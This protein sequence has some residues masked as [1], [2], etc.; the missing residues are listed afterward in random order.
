MKVDQTALADGLRVFWGPALDH[1]PA[2]CSTFGET[3]WAAAMVRSHR[4]AMH[5]LFHLMIDCFLKH[6][7]AGGGIPVTS[8]NGALGVTPRSAGIAMPVAAA[9]VVPVSASGRAPRVNWAALD[10]RLCGEVRAAEAAIRAVEP[11]VRVTRAEIERRVAR[12]DWFGKR[13]RK[14]PRAVAVLQRLEEPVGEYR[15]R[16]ATHWIAALGPSCRPWEV[17]R[18]AGLRSEHL[19]MIRAAMATRAASAGR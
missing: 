6:L 18:A 5:P 16:R 7:Q 13:R 1:L 14:V 4:K 9:P 15:R 19:P 8:S 12:T 10:D 17:M 11:P 2:P 3:G